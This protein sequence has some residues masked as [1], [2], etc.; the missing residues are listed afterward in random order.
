MLASFKFNNIIHTC[1]HVLGCFLER[2]NWV[3]GE[4]SNSYLSKGK[5]SIT[6]G[7]EFVQANF[8]FGCADLG[9]KTETVISGQ[10]DSGIGQ[11]PGRN[12]WIIINIFYFKIWNL[13]KEFVIHIL[14]KTSITIIN[15]QLQVIIKWT[16]LEY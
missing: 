10:K 5:F 14:I 8:I 13:I 2:I 12:I 11:Y 15:L 6:I 9:G 3:K 4:G 1:Q 7:S 16:K